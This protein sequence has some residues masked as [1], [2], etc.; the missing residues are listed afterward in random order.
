MFSMKNMAKRGT[1][2][3]DGYVVLWNEGMNS[4]K[5]RL[6]MFAWF[7]KRALKAK[8]PIYTVA[9]EDLGGLV[10]GW[11]EYAMKD[12]NGNYNLSLLFLNY[13]LI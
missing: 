8:K 9:P 3:S 10:M 7:K 11:Y 12:I 6:E 13:I 4:C 2:A 1:N 5:D